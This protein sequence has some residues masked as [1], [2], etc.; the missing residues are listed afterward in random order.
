MLLTKTFLRENL[1]IARFGLP[2]A[3]STGRAAADVVAPR[4]GIPLVDSEQV[5]VFHWLVRRNLLRDGAFRVAASCWGGFRRNSGNA[6]PSFQVYSGIPR[7]S[8]AF[9]E[10]VSGH[11]AHLFTFLK[12]REY[13]DCW[14]TDWFVLWTIAIAHVLSRR[15]YGDKP[16]VFCE[17]MFKESSLCNRLRRRSSGVRFGGVFMSNFRSE[18]TRSIHLFHWRIWLRA[19]Q[20]L[21]LKFC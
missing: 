10:A 2:M 17:I 11:S 1:S 9:P 20:V 13:I 15:S 21:A 16:C 19:F 8:S 5:H 4:I 14:A 7:L 3:N 18:L 6:V 12:L